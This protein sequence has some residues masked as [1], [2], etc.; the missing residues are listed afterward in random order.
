MPGVAI[1]RG[2][3]SPW[4]ENPSP[5]SARID[6]QVMSRSH[7]IVPDRETEHPIGYN[8]EGDIISLQAV[9]DEGEDIFLWIK[10]DIIPEWAASS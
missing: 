10:K 6:W 8:P 7:L 3:L 5:M 4:G 1:I 9:T 2:S